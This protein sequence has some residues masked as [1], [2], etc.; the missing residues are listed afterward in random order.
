MVSLGDPLA[1]ERTKT[2]FQ[3]F[4]LIVHEFR[5]LREKYIRN[6]S[7]SIP[8]SF[9]RVSITH[10]AREAVMFSRRRARARSSESMMAAVPS[11]SLIISVRTSASTSRAASAVSGLR[12]GS[13]LVILLLYHRRIRIYTVS[14]CVLRSEERRVGKECRS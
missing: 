13:G 4:H 10:A 9:A 7:P 3:W 6:S 14:D 12:P 11:R 5:K 1:H 2:R 8:A